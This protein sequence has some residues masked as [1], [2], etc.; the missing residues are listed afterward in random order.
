M[1]PAV[2]CSDLKVA[3]ALL[4]KRNAYYYTLSQACQKLKPPKEAGAKPVL[5]VFANSQKVAPAPLVV[6]N[7]YIFVAIRHRQLVTNMGVSPLPLL[8]LLNHAFRIVLQ[9]AA[10][11]SVDVCGCDDRRHVP[12]AV[13]SCG[14]PHVGCRSV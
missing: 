9:I 5:R 14:D 13:G 11:D 2:L 12:G 10:T 4:N 7:H 1:A 6:F 8:P 3:S